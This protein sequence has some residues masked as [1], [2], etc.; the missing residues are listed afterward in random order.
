MACRFKRAVFGGVALLATALMA[1]GCVSYR[2]TKIEIGQPVEKAAAEQLK[3]GETTLTEALRLLG[4]PDRI[5]GLAGRNLLIYRRSL[6][7]ENSVSVSVP[8]T[9]FVVLDSAEVSAAGGLVRFDILAL[10]FTPEGILE[11]AVLESGSEAPYLE[12]LFREG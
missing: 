1:A 3:S 7:Y 2:L 11:K 5:I 10:F 8:L 12:T 9:D 6:S 4:A